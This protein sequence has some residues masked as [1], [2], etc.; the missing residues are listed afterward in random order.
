MSERSSGDG[1]KERQVA[2]ACKAGDLAHLR[3]LIQHRTQRGKPL[4]LGA[5]QV[6]PLVSAARSEHADIVRELLAARARVELDAVDQYNR[7][8]LI[9][10]AQ[11]N[12]I[13]IMEMFIDAG[14]DVLHTDDHPRC[15][16]TYAIEYD[17]V[18]AI[19]LLLLHAEKTGACAELLVN[20]C[21]HGHDEVVSTLLAHTSV[22]GPKFRVWP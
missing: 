5:G 8:A 12:N 11:K 17:H 3:S 20:A 13:P 15:A 7:T 4:W 16:L 9:Y 18:E 1:H 14:A 2:E 10:A 6:P 19:S 22:H 21:C